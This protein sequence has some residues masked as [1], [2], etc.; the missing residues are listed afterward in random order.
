[1]LLAFLAYVS[2]DVVVVR[3]PIQLFVYVSR[4][5]SRACV[6]CRSK[7]CRCADQS[8]C[9]TNERSA[10]WSDMHIGESLC[11][12]CATAISV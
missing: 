12:S 6:A 7:S 8:K 11:D 4:L 9:L 1:M 3:L 5:S 10:K 2:M